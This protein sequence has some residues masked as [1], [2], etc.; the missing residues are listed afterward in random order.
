MFQISFGIV[1]SGA[2]GLSLRILHRLR[3]ELRNKVLAAAGS[4]PVPTG[5]TRL[6]LDVGQ[7]SLGF[8]AGRA[9]SEGRFGDQ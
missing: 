6:A 2:P 7:S 9:R 8:V 3:K 1:S 5:D 4:S